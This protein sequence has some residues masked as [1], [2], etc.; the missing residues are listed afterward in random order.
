MKILRINFSEF[1]RFIV[2]DNNKITL[3]INIDK[4]D[5]F[6]IFEELGLWSI[7]EIIKSLIS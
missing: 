5:S 7:E 2:I 3:I 6:V 4:N 1:I